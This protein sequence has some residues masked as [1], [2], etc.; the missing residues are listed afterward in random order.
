M[1]PFL[2]TQAR[3][4]G[5]ALLLGGSALAVPSP[6]AFQSAA[7][8][9]PAPEAP[10]LRLVALAFSPVTPGNVGDRVRLWLVNWGPAAHRVEIGCD[11]LVLTVTDLAT[12]RDVTADV[13]E[14][15]A[16]ALGLPELELIPFRPVAV[17]QGFLLPALA[18]LPSGLYRLTVVSTG[19]SGTLKADTILQWRP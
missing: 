6:V 10:D 15:L 11:A 13:P 14:A 1:S 4:W 9:G 3:C 7:N 19:P 12:G 16:C 2:F 5:L 8:P 17:G 18:H